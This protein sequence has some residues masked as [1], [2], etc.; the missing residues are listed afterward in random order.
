MGSRFVVTFSFGPSRL[1]KVRTSSGRLRKG[2]RL[3][4]IVRRSVDIFEKMENTEAETFA[5]LLS[6]KSL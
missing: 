3:G 6:K 1:K 5:K 4:Y 2:W